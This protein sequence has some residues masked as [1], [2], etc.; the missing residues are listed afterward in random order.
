MNLLPGMSAEECLRLCHIRRDGDIATACNH[1]I[2][3]LFSA[4]RMNDA[5]VALNNIFDIPVSDLFHSHIIIEDNYDFELELNN[6]IK[7]A[8][9][10]PSD[11]TTISTEQHIS[12]INKEHIRPESAI[13]QFAIN[14]PLKV[15]C[16]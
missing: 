10:I 13:T 2:Y 7:H 16:K 3:I 1:A 14:K 11:A 4:V 9:D 6:I 15:R 12:S 8:V 5:Q